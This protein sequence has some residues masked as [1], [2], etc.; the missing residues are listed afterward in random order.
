MVLLTKDYVKRMME[1]HTSANVDEAMLECYRIFANTI[2]LLPPE[3]QLSDFY[4]PSKTEKS[5][6]LLFVMVGTG[7]ATYVVYKYLK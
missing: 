4:H 2:K 5:G 3:S 1:R 6:E 7:L